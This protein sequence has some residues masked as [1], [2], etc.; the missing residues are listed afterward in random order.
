MNFKVGTVK[1][2]EPYK[3]SLS[4]EV[5]AWH[6]EVEFPAGEHDVYL[7][8]VNGKGYLYTKNID[9]VITE[10][11]TPSL[12][13]GIVTGDR[14]GSEDVGKTYSS[15]LS[16]YSGMLNNKEH[17]IEFTMNEIASQWISPG[18]NG[19]WQ[20]D[21]SH[22]EFKRYDTDKKAERLLEK[23]IKE[24]FMYKA[25]YISKHGFDKA[26]ILRNAAESNM[27]EHVYTHVIAMDQ[28]I[29]KASNQGIQDLNIS[30]SDAS[31]YLNGKSGMMSTVIARSARD[32]MDEHN[33]KREKP[34]DIDNDFSM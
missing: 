21:K 19:E 14:D 7:N 6:T 17:N 27:S 29:R 2:K 20:I 31:K 1:V 5:A 16:M 10:N 23:A 24:P 32:L 33:V 12:F 4:H 30:V 18:Y 34:K 9:G 15:G 3:K 11:Y 28:L 25:D 22:S 13:G 26:D 8:I